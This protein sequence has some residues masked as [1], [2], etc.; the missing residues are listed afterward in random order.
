MSATRAAAR[1]T[2]VAHVVS[3]LVIIAIA[4]EVFVVDYLRPHSLFGY[5]VATAVLGGLIATMVVEKSE[6]RLTSRA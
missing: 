1:A 5:L 6:L 4:S 2:A 3:I